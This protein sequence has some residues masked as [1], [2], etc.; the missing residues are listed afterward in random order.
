MPITAYPPPNITA[1]CSLY[2]T[3]IRQLQASTGVVSWRRYSDDWGRISI[4]GGATQL[5]LSTD[6][7]PLEAL[8]YPM[9][10]LPADRPDILLSEA[11][12][13]LARAAQLDAEPSTMV[14]APNGVRYRCALARAGHLS[15]VQLVEVS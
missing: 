7:Q 3:W 13:L 6:R 12:L 9:G 8:L 4:D 1:L 5:T 14:T 10:M 11:T 15:T 2:D